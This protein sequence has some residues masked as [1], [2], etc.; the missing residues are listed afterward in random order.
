MAGEISFFEIGVQDA[1]QGRAFYQELFGWD[2]EPGPTGNGPLLRA[3]R[4]QGGI[5]GGDAEGGTYLF[6][7]VDDMDAAIERVRQLGGRLHEYD[8]STQEDPDVAAAYGRFRLCRD[9]QG[10]T[11]G[12]HQPP[13]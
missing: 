12:L 13:A 1:E 7:R 8:L 9:D 10:S 6:F 2:T 5:H 4:T 11:F 3:G